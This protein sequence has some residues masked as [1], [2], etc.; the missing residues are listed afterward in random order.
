[1]ALPASKSIS[2]RALILNALC[3]QKAQISN[4]AK[5]CKDGLT[6]GSTLVKEALDAIIEIT[7]V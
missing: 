3:A 5:G 4:I 7:E 1:M 6:D 2:N